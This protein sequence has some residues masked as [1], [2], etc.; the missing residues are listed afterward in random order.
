MFVAACCCSSDRSKILQKCN[1]T[2]RECKNILQTHSL[3][4]KSQVKSG[5]LRYFPPASSEET[6]RK[7]CI[8]LANLYPRPL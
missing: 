5:E 8:A 3:S 6:A 2:K 1:V 4:A 7:N